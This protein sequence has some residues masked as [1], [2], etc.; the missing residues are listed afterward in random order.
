MALGGVG[1]EVATGSGGVMIAGTVTVAG[2][3]TLVGADAVVGL[4]AMID[5]V[6][7]GWS[8]A[9]ASSATRARRSAMPHI[10]AHTTHA[11]ATYHVSRRRRATA[12]ARA[13]SSGV[14]GVFSPISP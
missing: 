6:D 5:G 1:A 8:P 4:V 11:E 9:E 3:T 7:Q 14:S 13:A 12:R 2:A 10:T